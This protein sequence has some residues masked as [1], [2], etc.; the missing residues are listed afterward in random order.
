MV[1]PNYT[2][3]NAEAALADPDSVFY[4]YQKLIRLVC[5][6]AGIA[7]PEATGTITA[8]PRSG[9]G[10]QGLILLETANAPGSYRLDEPMTDL[11]TG[12]E[13]CGVVELAPYDLLILEKK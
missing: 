12:K 9:N 8:I 3:I 6:D 5:E 13:Y 11:L 1:N 7:V 2:Q 10:R 4:Y